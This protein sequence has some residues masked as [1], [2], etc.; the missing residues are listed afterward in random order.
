M[1]SLA[2][3]NYHIVFLWYACQGSG[4]TLDGNYFYMVMN[5]RKVV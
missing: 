5:I 1:K 2:Y 4:F 3:D